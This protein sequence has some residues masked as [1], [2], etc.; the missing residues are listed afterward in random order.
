M[1]NAGQ[2]T[3]VQD[4]WRRGQEVSV[5][6]W[7]YT[8]ADGIY[9]DLGMSLNSLDD[10]SKL[11]TKTIADANSSAGSMSGKQFTSSFILIAALAVMFVPFGI[12]AQMSR[13]PTPT[14]EPLGAM[15]KKPDSDSNS[16][17]KID[18]S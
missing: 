14:R 13:K 6:G 12:S 17:G 10:T 7:I 5:H 2:T 3:I 16:I 9:K 4:A 11:R 1:I 15:A 8:I 18:S